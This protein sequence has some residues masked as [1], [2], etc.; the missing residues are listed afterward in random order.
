MSVYDELQQLVETEPDEVMRRCYGLLD[1]NPD[2]ALALVLMGVVSV[3]AERY[4]HAVNLFKRVVDLKP[5]AEAWSHL[6]LAYLGLKH[7]QSRYALQK[8][9]DLKQSA[10]NAANMACAHLDEQNYRKAVEWAEKALKMKADSASAWTSYGMA[11]LAL[12]NWAEGWKGY[13]WSLGGPF[14]KETQ[15]QEEPRWD[16]TSGKSL[17]VY[18]EQGLGDEI[19]YA[20]CVRDVARDNKVIL[21]C[22][23]RL[24]GLFGRSFPE[25]TVHGTRR[26]PAPWLEDVKLDARCAIGDLPRFYR[27]KL[28]EF[29]RKPYLVSDPERRLQWRALLDSFGKRKIGICWSGG[30]RHNH[31][32]AR[33]IGLEALRPLIESIDATWVSLQYKDPAAEIAATGLPVKHW[34]RACETADYDDTAALVSE[35]DL[36]IGVHTSVQHLAGALGVPQI[37][38]VP[39]K[40]LWLYAND[41]FPW[42]PARLVREAGNWRQALESIKNDSTVRGL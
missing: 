24:A 36:V 34:A 15:Y 16:G 14:R 41:D 13:A 38:L 18:G 42:Y 12:G 8:A 28:D 5:R 35:L 6:G 23:A 20:S 39:D 7:P 2:D 29:P 32:A 22:D 9:W 26:L 31:P 25:V 27:K 1:A 30:S 4:G 17:I 33:A 19:M 21:E 10:A 3:R 40:T 37:I 11:N